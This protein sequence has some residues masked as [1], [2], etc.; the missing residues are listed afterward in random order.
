MQAWLPNGPCVIIN[1]PVLART[2]ML[3]ENDRAVPL[4]PFSSSAADI[5][6]DQANIVSLSAACPEHNQKHTPDGLVR[7]GHGQYVCT[8][9]CEPCMPA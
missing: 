9:L 7:A 5:E 4:P 1:D 3:K 6:F 2:F 8:G